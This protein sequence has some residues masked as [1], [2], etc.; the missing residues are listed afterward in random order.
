MRSRSRS[1][2]PLWRAYSSIM[3]TSSSR[4]ESRL[5]LGVAADETEVVVARELLG[6]CD[7]LTPR[8]PRRLDHRPDRIDGKQVRPVLWCSSRA[9]R[10]LDGPRRPVG[11][12]RPPGSQPAA[13][14]AASNGARSNTNRL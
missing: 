5:T 10:L 1:A 14:R 7:L 2:C 13:R 12:C 3:C 11:P 8:R 6:E 9:P 4:S